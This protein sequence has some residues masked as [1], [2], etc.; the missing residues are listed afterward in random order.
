MAVSKKIERTITQ[1]SWIRKMF[2]DGL[3]L[4]KE[5]GAGNVFDF[6]LGNPNVEPPVSLKKAI[7]EVASDERP[8]VHA[9]MPNAGLPETRAALAEFLGREQGINLSADHVIVT[10]GAAGALNVILKTILDPG[11]EILI[12][13]PFFVE[14]LAY[15]DNHGGSAKP[16]KTKEDFSL[17]LAAIEK[18][19]SERTKAVLINS[20]NNPTG[21]VY[22][23]TEL[24]GLAEI[25]SAKGKK[26]GR[27]IHVIS[28]EPYDKIV[29]D[30]VKVPRLLKIYRESLIVSS[31]SKTLSIPG[32]R[33][34]FIAVHPQAEAVETLMGGFIM[35]NR[36]LGFVNAPAF[37]QRVLPKVLGAR[38]SVEDYQRKRDLL[39]QGLAE[40]GYDFVKPEGAFYLFPKTPIADDV[41]FVRR[42]QGRNILTVPGSGFGC[43]GYFRIAYCVDDATIVNAMKGFGE[44][45]EECR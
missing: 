36:V 27:V 7:L 22:T 20:P 26:L 31:Y 29:Y 19:I 2:E 41:E 38:V 15:A 24:R 25:L 45:M 42:L 16:V 34:G 43:P 4:K 12:M 9:Y 14:Y 37:I 18:S 32:E 5:F 21:R 11:D 6:S 40:R 23:E 35:C 1:Q 28:D 33:I 13:A 30:G 39:C 17:D 10:C 3:R 8:G 44:V